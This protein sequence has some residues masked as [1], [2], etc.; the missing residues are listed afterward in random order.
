MLSSP[1]DEGPEARRPVS[2]AAKLVFGLAL[3]VQ[4]LAFLVSVFGDIGFDKPG[5]FGLDFGHYLVLVGVWFG[6]A[7][8]GVCVA[9]MRLG[10]LALLMQLVLFAAPIVWPLLI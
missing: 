8:L 4:L 10:L 6:A 9:W 5:R 2:A 3:V 1:Q 7:C